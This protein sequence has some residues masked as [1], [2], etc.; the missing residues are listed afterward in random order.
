MYTGHNTFNTVT[1]F[2]SLDIKFVIIIKN[3]LILHILHSML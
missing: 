1:I 3:R 2:L